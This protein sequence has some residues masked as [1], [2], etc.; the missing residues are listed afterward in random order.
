[1]RSFTIICF[2]LLGCMP[3]PPKNRPAL[4]EDL[5]K[6]S[7]SIDQK[8]DLGLLF[9]LADAEKIVGE[10]VLWLDS[11]TTTS[12]RGTT[13]QSSYQAKEKDPKSKKTGNVYFLVTK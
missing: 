12:K 8:V 2:L 4:D 9:T 6:D 3:T 5:P 10:P 11:S 1:M 7:V 13:Y